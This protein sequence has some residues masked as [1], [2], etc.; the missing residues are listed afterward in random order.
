MTLAHFYRYFFSSVI[1]LTVISCKK[2]SQTRAATNADVYIAGAFPGFVGTASSV[3]Y[4][5]NGV[6]VKL[7][8]SLSGLT[9]GIIVNG[10]DVYAAG[11]TFKSGS[12]SYINSG[13]DSLNQQT[14]TTGTYWHN[15]V[16]V[17]V[18]I[19]T[20]CTAIAV[21]GNDVYVAGYTSTPNTNNNGGFVQ[22]PASTQNRIGM[23]WKNGTPVTF[24]P[25]TTC[26]SIVVIGSD[27]Y[28]TGAVN[29]AAAYWKN[30]VLVK[31]AG[32]NSGSIANAI[33]FSSN[34]M[35]IVG[36]IYIT[37]GN[38]H[39]AYW[40]NGALIQF[41]QDASTA[42]GIAING[43]DLYIA[44]C[45]GEAAVF[46]K[47]GAL[48]VLQNP[49]LAANVAEAIAVNNNTVYAAGLSGLQ[50]VYWQNGIYQQLAFS[51][52]GY[53]IAVVPK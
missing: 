11:Y 33:A 53:G 47:N 51:G 10:A 32:S 18:G 12:G 39:A 46:W 28:V 17:T 13:N 8:D 21:S 20:V 45:A 24:G 25:N 1:I 31:L 50:A 52:A 7:N 43:S 9:Y 5:K 4:W 14:I 27:V 49:G 15:G 34:T 30:G 40:Q 41:T 35:Y 44:G 26:T 16:A 48:N 23:Y 3:G 36:T 38:T 42:N 22:F 19:N 37:G 6:E 2:N 29:D